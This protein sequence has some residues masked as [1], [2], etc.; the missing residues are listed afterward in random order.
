MRIA[1]IAAHEAG[2]CVISLALGLPVDL[3][4][5]DPPCCSY[6]DHTDAWH[7]GGAVAPALSDRQR[8]R[9]A[10]I[11]A[12]AGPCAEAKFSGESIRTCLTRN[13]SDRATAV[14]LALGFVSE[15]TD[16][17]GVLRLALQQTRRL[18]D[19]CWPEILAVAR[20]LQIHSALY[21]FEVE[22]IVRRAQLA[23]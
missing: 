19:R 22:R 21:G 8:W 18:V 2:H 1:P 10:T 20:A 15:D 13:A 5:L 11:R 14:D 7:G 9:A 4:S 6:S 12:L 23:A 3:L 16:I 17:D